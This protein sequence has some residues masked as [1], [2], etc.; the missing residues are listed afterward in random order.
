MHSK[1]AEAQ[2]DYAA[3]V[4]VKRAAKNVVSRVKCDFT[5]TLCDKPS[6]NNDNHYLY[7]LA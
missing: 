1:C 3:H 6:T 5:T 2:N 7:H 4:I